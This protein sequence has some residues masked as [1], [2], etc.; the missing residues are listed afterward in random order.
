[1][2]RFW[3]QSRKISRL[4]QRAALILSLSTSPL[5]AFDG[6][7]SVPGADEDLTALLTLATTSIA[8]E[9][10][11]LDSARQILAA[12]LTD[13]RTLVTVLY[14]RGYF[15]PVVSIRLNGR[16]AANILPR[17]L[18]DEVSSVAVT[19]D[20]GPIYQFGP[21]QIAPLAEG[22]DLPKSF[23]TGQTAT[24]GAI[25]D[26]GNVAVQ[27]WRNTGHAKAALGEQSV[28]AR[29]DRQQLDVAIAVKQGPKLRFGKMSVA[30]DS[31]VRA[32][33][34]QRIAGFPSGEVFSPAKVRKVSS[35]LQRTGA[36]AGV[37]VSEAQTPNP[38]G[39]LDFT[40]T[41]VDQRLRRISLG[42]E[43]SSRNGL[44]LSAI[45]TH[46]NLFGAAERLRLEGR[47]RNIGGPE[48]I[49]G[50][51]SFRLDEPAKLGP[52][53]TLFWT[54]ALELRNKPFYRLYS[55][56][57]GVGARHILANNFFV[58]VAGIPKFA[59][60]DDAF[61]DNRPFDLILLPVLA[62]LD[63]RN[64]SLDPSRGYYAQALVRPM[65]GLRG[66]KTSATGILDGRVHLGLFSDR[67]VLAGR[68]KLGTTFGAEIEEISPEFLFYSGGAGT[69]RGQ[70]Y[71][72]LGVPVGNSLA[73]GRSTFILN[74]EARVGITQT[75]SVVGFYD[76]GAVGAG[77]FI[78]DTAP[79]QAGAGVGLRYTVPGFGP[80]R[81]DVA[82]PT[83]G[84]TGS[85]VQ[86]Y[87]G[88]GQAF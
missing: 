1:M 37:T 44:E 64:D 13:Y 49:D 84:N 9:E 88:I 34:V 86:I 26:A 11:N 79:S 41:V 25:R 12:A 2:A 56:S 81:A 87:L 23:A 36:F 30:G 3:H 17:D 15:S 54:G 78:D 21:V 73:G 33:A 66:S 6:S 82:W 76:Y 22:T 67:L 77:E 47:I 59:R 83:L 32:E 71:E 51:L 24:T 14:D 29:H 45:W 50:I 65:I 61:G 18:G 40:T 53:T 35:R 75:V 57:A 28:I 38:D 16:E 46:R 80:L 70:P 74:A 20:T 27:A 31:G 72:G 68:A 7:I 55:L 69:V 85:G 19:I 39:T 42:G 52:D 58:E 5:L 60:S 4:A 62:E 10:N 43:Y 48:D 63:R 8:P